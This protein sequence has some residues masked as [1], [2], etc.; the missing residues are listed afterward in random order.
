M[1]EIRKK[2]LES[3]IL[4]EI[5]ELIMRMRIRDDRLGLVSVT[6]VD[7]AEDLGYMTVL[8]SPFG[9]EAENRETWEALADHAKAFQTS[10]GRDL[11]LRQTPTLTFAIDDRIKEGDRIIEIMDAQPP[12]AEEPPPA[13]QSD[14][15]YRGPG[16]RD[17]AE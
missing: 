9:S 2:R 1:N 15:P 13:G 4:R 12:L 11:R 10:V 3:A 6:Q 14:S 8:V 5:S 16:P 17:S 7:L